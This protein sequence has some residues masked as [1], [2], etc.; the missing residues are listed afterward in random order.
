MSVNIFGSSGKQSSKS[1]NKYVDRKFITLTTNLNSKMDL[2]VSK[3]G[4]IMSGILNLGSNAIK[5]THTPISGE[6]VINKRYFDELIS[7]RLNSDDLQHI[8]NKLS[9]K[10]NRTGDTLT[11]PV[12]FGN[13]RLTSTYIPSNDN[14]ILNKK[15]L[16]SIYIKNSHGY[17]PELIKKSPNKSGFI[18]T[19]SGDIPEYPAYS[20]F[21]PWK[22]HWLPSDKQN[23]WLPI[24]PPEYVR[25]YKFSLCGKVTGGS[26]TDQINSFSLLAR[27]NVSVDWEVL[28]T[29]TD[30]P[31]GT[32]TSFFHVNNNSTFKLFKLQIHSSVGETPGLSY[33]Q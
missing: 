18:I 24:E 31:L 2:K 20:A 4:D 8:E 33:F 30:E 3:S 10:V 7:R 15:F 32:D 23:G 12:D 11:G 22:P 13:N 21:T 16:K 29:T 9:L 28:F 6:D 25:I 27:K 5:T 19:S 14:D 1:D 17:I 26:L